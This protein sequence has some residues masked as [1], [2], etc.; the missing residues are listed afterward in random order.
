MDEKIVLV[1]YTI[2]II[3]KEK[4]EFSV[5]RVRVILTDYAAEWYYGRKFLLK[6]TRH[7][8]SIRKTFDSNI[9]FICMFRRSNENNDPGISVSIKC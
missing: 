1:R 8:R 2:L 4:S 3:K 6:N 9:L 5:D 7:K